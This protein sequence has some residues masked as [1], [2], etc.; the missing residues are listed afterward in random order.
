MGV[1]QSKS[2]FV[3]QNSN[4]PVTFSTQLVNRL[5]EMDGKVSMDVGTDVGMDG[6]ANG[7][8]PKVNDQLHRLQ[9]QR[10]IYEQHDTNQ[11]EREMQDLINQQAYTVT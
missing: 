1:N 7:L 8:N 2:T 6:K 11:M 5:E 4:L 9:K 10:L 3:L